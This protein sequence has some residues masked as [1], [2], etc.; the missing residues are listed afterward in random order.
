MRVGL[1]LT[2][3]SSAGAR[4]TA[5]LVNELVAIPAGRKEIRRIDRTVRF[6]RSDIGLMDEV[7]YREVIDGLLLLR[8][9]KPAFLLAS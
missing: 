8:V 1:V 4:A 2:P 9:L 3:P 5:E 7:V 6:R